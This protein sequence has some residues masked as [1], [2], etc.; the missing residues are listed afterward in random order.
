MYYPIIKNKLN[1]LKGLEA[2]NS[3]LNFIPILEIVDCKYEDQEKFFDSFMSKISSTA[4]S[5]KIFIDFPTYADNDALNV[6]ELYYA[7]DKFDFLITLEQYFTSKGY[8]PFIPVISFD[9]NYSS[10]RESYKENIKLVKKISD[11]FSNGFAFRIFSD[12]SFKNEDKDLISQSYAFLD[13]DITEKCHLII[14]CDKNIFTEA[15]PVIRELHD[16]GY[17]IKNIIL[18]GEAYNGSIRIETGIFCDRI[19]NAQIKR[20]ENIKTQLALNDIHIDSINYA[21][22]SLLEKIQ[23]KIEV[24]PDKGF[25]YYP[26]IKYTTED[27]NLCMFTADTK[28]NYHQ[29]EELCRR[30]RA[31]IHTFSDTHCDSCKFISDVAAGNIENFKAGST[32]KHRMI[33]HHITALAMLGV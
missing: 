31:N 4:K 5:K 27:G 17:H 25:L 28:G 13:E 24:D 15:I 8:M 3:A 21:D 29:Y 11:H 2:V 19:G 1:E 14:D 7:Q 9:Y 12:S 16:D 10:Q 32:W 20:V 30:V 23:S 33:A 22:F 6:F 18:A 26:F